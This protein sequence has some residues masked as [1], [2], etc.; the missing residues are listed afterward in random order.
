VSAIE[1][2][3]LYSQRLGWLPSEIVPGAQI[4][5]LAFVTAVKQRQAALHVAPEDGICGPATYRAVLVER[6][7][8]LR[9]MASAPPPAPPAT[10]LV[11]AGQIAVCEAKNAWCKNIVDDLNDTRSI[12]LIDPLIRT[13]LGIGWTWEEPYRGNFQWCGTFAAFAWRSMIALA[14]RRSFFSSN[15]R[16]DRWARYQSFEQTPNPRPSVGPYRSFLELDEKS[17]ATDVLGFGGT[18]PRPGDI[19]LVGGVNT[20]YGKHITIVE[21]YNASSGVF[22]TLE[23]NGTGLG[24]NGVRQHGVVRATRRIGLSTGAPQTTYFARRLIRPAPADLKL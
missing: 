14:T 18:D 15:Y 22:T 10:L 19:L 24:P 3:A 21:S 12:G 9:Q 13:D 4:V 11:V 20:A 23:G 7:A 1:Q 17:T 16:L 6:A 8:K 2:N 5:D